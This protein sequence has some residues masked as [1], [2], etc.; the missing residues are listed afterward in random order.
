MYKLTVTLPSCLLFYLVIF[1]G[2]S[3]NKDTSALWIHHEDP[4]DFNPDGGWCWFQDERGLIDNGILLFA[5]VSSKG[6]IILTRYDFDTGQSDTLNI[7]PRF[8]RNDHA[9]PALM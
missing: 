5:S 7:H 2:C 4:V 6:D 8:L 3:F 1:S 9:Q